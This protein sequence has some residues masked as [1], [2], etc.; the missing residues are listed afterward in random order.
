[1]LNLDSP[2]A[3]DVRAGLTG[4]P[5][6]LSARWLYDE[7]GS[8]LFDEITRLPEYYPTETERSIL[9]SRAHD[10]ARISGATTVIELGSGT[11]DKTTT[12][13]DAFDVHRQL[14]TFIPID[15]SSEILVQA[16]DR[17]RERYP[18]AT[19]TPVVSDFTQNLGLPAGLTGRKLIAFLGGTI[20]NFYPA[21]RHEFLHRIVSAMTPG[22]TLLLGTD[23][24]KNADRLVAAY[25]DTDGVTE[26][27]ILNMLTMLNTTLD[28]DFDINAFQYL[29]LWDATNTR[30]DLRLRSL[31]D[32]EVT[33]PGAGITVTFTQGEEVLIEISTKFRVS[34]LASE[35]H[36]VGLS[37]LE[38]MTDPQR[39]FALTLARLD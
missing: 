17:L 26:R 15:I 29:P 39:D 12:L 14:A 13:L 32:Q 33:I 9:Q 24:V 28:A 22:D 35:L 4:T 25:D 6:S 16:A 36:A 5:K 38:V 20:G 10:I 2:L 18:H 3:V 21:E 8:I 19:I 30:M 37:P 11:S 7:A 1:M 34:A 23:L 31:R 27:F